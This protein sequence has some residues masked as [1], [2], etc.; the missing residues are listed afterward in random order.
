MTMEMI[1]GFHFGKYG[2]V[3]T[4]ETTLIGHI[5]DVVWSGCGS[6]FVAYKEWGSVMAMQSNYHRLQLIVFTNN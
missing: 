2:V 4:E 5:C 1:F 3:S 6:N